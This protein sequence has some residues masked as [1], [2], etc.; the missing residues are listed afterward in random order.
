MLLR[1]PY[2]SGK[3]GKATGLEV[4]KYLLLKARLLTLPLYLIKKRERYLTFNIC[5]FVHTTE[6]CNAVSHN[7]M[8]ALQHIPPIA[9]TLRL[10]PC[11]LASM[12]TTAVG[13][14][15]IYMHL[16]SVSCQ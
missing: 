1:F 16:S 8:D 2:S 4:I 5:L 9:T 10:S 3:K 13:G 6:C 15:E 14:G 7:N 11:V 12:A